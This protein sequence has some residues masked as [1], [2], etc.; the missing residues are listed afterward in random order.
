MRVLLA[1]IS[2][3]L[4]DLIC[5]LPVL[6]ALIESGQTTYLVLRSSAQ[7]G[8]EERIEGLAGAINE[9]DLS[10]ALN[11][12]GTR[13]IN[14]RDHPLQKDH[15]W[16][17]PAFMQDFS[18]LH[19]DEIVRRIARD[20]GVILEAAEPRPLKANKLTALEGKVLFIPGSRGSQKCWPAQNWLELARLLAQQNLNTVVIG[21]PEQCIEVKELLEAGLSWYPTP[22]LVAALDAVSSARAVIGAD[23]GLMHLAVQQLTPTVAL[24]RY[25][26]VFARKLP[27]VRSLIAPICLTECLELEF[28]SDCN[29]QL[30]FAKPEG[31]EEEKG[32]AFYWTTWKCQAQSQER[33]MNRIQVASVV[34]ALMELLDNRA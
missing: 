2:N 32:E 15:V 34:E 25:N 29:T 30:T 23:T 21:Q 12:E 11:P 9:A 7:A 28:A 13:L 22:S 14:L 27:H 8:L 24:F 19:I 6:Q 31:K 5:S 1:P 17:S 10:E 16:G 3:G 33:C 20:F 18:D 4:G 26:A